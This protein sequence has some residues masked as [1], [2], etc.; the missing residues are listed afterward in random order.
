MQKLGRATAT[1]NAPPDSK[2]Q[3][4]ARKANPLFH[5]SIALGRSSAALIFPICTIICINALTLMRH[6]VTASHSELMTYSE[7][8]RDP[9]LRNERGC[10]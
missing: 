8:F 5:H 9:L 7:Y 1:E 3:L 4:P 10:F 2:E 6:F